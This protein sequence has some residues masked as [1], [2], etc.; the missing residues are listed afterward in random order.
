MTHV[1]AFLR[2]G[3]GTRQARVL[4]LVAIA[5]VFCAFAGFAW[6]LAG[7]E[8]N[9]SAAS[10]EVL[11]PAAGNEFPT[12]GFHNAGEVTVTNRAPSGDQVGPVWFANGVDAVPGDAVI[13]LDTA[14]VDS[15][16]DFSG[17]RVFTPAG[18]ELAAIETSGVPLALLRNSAKELLISDEPNESFDQFTGATGRLTAFD[19]SHKL[20]P[21]WQLE[22]P[23]RAGYLLYSSPLMALTG[24]EQY[25]V[26]LT[27]RWDSSDVCRDSRN[28]DACGVFGVGIVHLLDEPVVTEVP[29]P[30][31]CGGGRLFAA[32]PRSVYVTCY[33]SAQLFLLSADDGRLTPVS[34]GGPSPPLV[35]AFDRRD[36][37]VGVLFAD[38]TL[39]VIGDGKTIR[40]V[41]TIPVGARI[42]PLG[43]FEQVGTSLLI[44]YHIPSDTPLA[45]VALFDLEQLLVRWQFANSDDV[46]GVPSQDS[47]RVLVTGTVISVDARNGA[48]GLF[49]GLARH[50]TLVLVR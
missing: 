49:R 12:F 24:D 41:R 1:S 33:Y 22:L 47:A 44:P 21:K 28:G 16:T 45:G 17:A 2:Q 20:A 3:L 48:H 38:G 39:R 42:V 8:G 14:R 18:V 34:L 13:V 10:P 43:Q 46:F 29:L 26:Y 7:G 40:E 32:G 15:A 37:T 27:Q 11:R 23:G 50:S 31:G 25:L 6:V 5:I 9:E 19:L 35:G 4:T 36:G 30:R